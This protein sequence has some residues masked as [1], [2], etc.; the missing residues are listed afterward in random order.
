M[1]TKTTRKKAHRAQRQRAE[2]TAAAEDEEQ[3]TTPA[4][5]EDAPENQPEQVAARSPQGSK[6]AAERAE[7]EKEDRERAREQAEEVA[8]A[9]A[10]GRAPKTVKPAAQA[11]ETRRFLLLGGEHEEKGVVYVYSRDTPVVVESPLPLDK[12]FMNKFRALDGP[13]SPGQDFR[14]VADRTGLL[15]A[16]L[17]VR[18]PYGEPSQFSR[19]TDLSAQQDLA[20]RRADTDVAVEDDPLLTGQPAYRGGESPAGHG[21]D[22]TEF[23]DGADKADVKITKRGGEYRVYDAD[24]PDKPLHAEPL[25]SKK[26]VD[27]FLSGL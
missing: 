6:A 13:T 7:F 1:A 19:D 8:A 16:P 14:D 26:D 12:K 24:K 17:A 20:R 3:D 4:D 9:Q 25:A 27:E 15:D 10:E 18:K 5:A 22:V 11:K 21:E 23:F 2:D